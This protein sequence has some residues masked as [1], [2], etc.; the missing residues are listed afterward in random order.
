M[1]PTAKMTT[2]TIKRIWTTLDPPPLAAVV[3]RVSV[4]S[5]VGLK[6]NWTL[7]W[8]F[9]SKKIKILLFSHLVRNRYANG[10][11]SAPATTGTGALSFTFQSIAFVTRVIDLLVTAHLCQGDL[12]ISW[13]LRLAAFQSTCTFR[14]FTNRLNDKWT[15]YSDWRTFPLHRR[16]LNSRTGARSGQKSHL[17]SVF[18]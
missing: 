18:D 2:R 12:S 15:T 13:D 1:S 10:L 5:M 11:L 16:P 4:T 14:Y 8:N 17:G 9:N 3:G 7:T 6:F